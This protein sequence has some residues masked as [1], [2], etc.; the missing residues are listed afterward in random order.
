MS[1]ARTA[2]RRATRFLTMLAGAAVAVGLTVALPG[3]ADA[4][5]VYSVMNT[6]EYP[7]DGIYFRSSPND[8]DAIRAAGIGVFA[9]ERVALN[10]WASGTNVQR[11]DGGVNTVWYQAANVSR[12]T[13]AGRANE[14]WINAHFID[15]RTGPN[16]VA[17]GVR[18]CGA[19]VP[20][21]IPAP[22]PAP[23]FNAR[24][25]T[26]DLL[27]RSSMA[28][29][30]TLGNQQWNGTSN[31]KELKPGQLDWATDGCSVPLMPTWAKSRPLGFN[32]Y[33]ACWRHD[34]GYRNYKPQGR[35]TEDNR[36]Q[37]DDNFLRDMNAIC[38][39]YRGLDS[40]RGVVCRNT[41]AR[42]YYQVVR[43]CG[44]SPTV[45][46]TG[47]ILKRFGLLP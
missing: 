5:T 1:Y 25:A 36:Q 46:C 39:T 42:A 45:A 37:I 17:P 4:A 43:L 3:A 24:A 7:P 10:C 35:L 20:A 38:N 2:R 29:F 21:P 14:G 34:F 41:A 44:S 31:E 13:A 16:Q 11:R 32:F 19:Q 28:Q 23:A 15:D 12:T 18:A 9:G 40:G 33:N 6:S 26:D 47:P 22:A 27:F 30:V 8:A